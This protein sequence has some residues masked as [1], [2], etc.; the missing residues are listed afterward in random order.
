MRPPAPPPFRPPPP[1]VSHLADPTPGSLQPTSAFVSGSVALTGLLP[2][3]AGALSRDGLVTPVAMQQL[4]GAIVDHLSRVVPD[5][6][7]SAGDVVILS[8]SALS[9]EG[10]RL[11]QRLFRQRRRLQVSPDDPGEPRGASGSLAASASEGA[12]WALAVPSVPRI[13]G[14][15]IN[16]PPPACTAILRA[17]PAAAGAQSLV[18]NVPSRSCTVPS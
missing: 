15:P 10:Q 4:Q 16:H 13:R 2:D 11:L 7:L 14:L 3:G 17:K 9:S 8:V 18:P 5:V 1:H 12:W 6:P